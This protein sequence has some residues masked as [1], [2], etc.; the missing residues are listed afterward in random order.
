MA[1]LFVKTPNSLKIT[2]EPKNLPTGSFEDILIRCINENNEY[3]QKNCSK[4]P[5]NRYD[6]TCDGLVGGTEYKIEFITKKK[7][8]ADMIFENIAKQYTSNSN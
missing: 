2:L 5:I 6:C 3:K 8:W 7:Y 1:S 4:L